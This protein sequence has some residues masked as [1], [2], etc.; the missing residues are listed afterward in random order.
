MVCCVQVSQG[1][2]PGVLLLLDDVHLPG[3]ASREDSEEDSESD[4]SADEVSTRGL[5]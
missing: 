1:K 4:S 2:P 3:A 5:A